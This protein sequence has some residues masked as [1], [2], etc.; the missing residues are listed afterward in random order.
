MDDDSLTN[1]Q[2]AKTAIQNMEEYQLKYKKLY[3]SAIKKQELA[4]LALV[5]ADDKEREKKI[6]KAEKMQ[7]NRKACVKS[8]LSMIPKPEEV[9]YSQTTGRTYSEKIAPLSLW[10]AQMTQ[11]AFYFFH[12]DIVKTEECLESACENVLTS[13]YNHLLFITYCEKISMH[14]DILRKTARRLMDYKKPMEHFEKFMEE[15]EL[16][17]VETILTKIEPPLSI[18]KNIRVLHESGITPPTFEKRHA[19]VNYANKTLDELQMNKDKL[20][21]LFKTLQNTADKFHRQMEDLHLSI[22]NPVCQSYIDFTVKALERVSDIERWLHGRDK[23][24][25]AALQKNKALMKLIGIYGRKSG[26]TTPAHETV[27]TLKAKELGATDISED[28]SIESLCLALTL[29]MPRIP[30][31]LPE[32][33]KPGDSQK[34]QLPENVKDSLVKMLQQM[35]TRKDDHLRSEASA[36]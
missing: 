6:K 33:S 31:T 19:Y 26:F 3:D 29:C 35:K 34:M 30:S 24:I 28:T 7:R 8:A 27:V 13:E 4:I 25:E 18:D 9:T 5:Q 16:E 22:S 36:W 11:A 1:C 17:T 15:I 23:K 21:I 14:S 12:G 10:E 2:R 20:N 32:P